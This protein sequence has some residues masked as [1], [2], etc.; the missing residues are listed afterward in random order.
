VCLYSVWR[1]LLAGWSEEWP[2]IL[3]HRACWAYI[4]ESSYTIQA[5]TLE[6]GIQ[7][8]GRFSLS[9]VEKHHDLRSVE[10]KLRILSGTLE[11]LLGPRTQPSRSQTFV[12]RVGY[13]VDFQ[14]SLGVA[15]IVDLVSEKIRRP[16]MLTLG[17][18]LNPSIEARYV[19]L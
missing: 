4:Q 6:A 15:L 9:C 13:E 18:R 8:A 3:T 11:S 19:S 2:Q 16:R 12:Q 5:E 14:Y 17:G 1:S 7:W 10:R